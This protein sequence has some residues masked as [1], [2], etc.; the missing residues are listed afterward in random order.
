MIVGKRLG[1]MVINLSQFLA[2]TILN[3]FNA[4]ARWMLMSRL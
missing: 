1:P 4:P 2:F 3:G